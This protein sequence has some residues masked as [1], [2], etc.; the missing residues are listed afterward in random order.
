MANNPSLNKFHWQSYTKGENAEVLIAGAQAYTAQTTYPNFQANAADGEV[1]VF[2]ATTLAVLAANGKLA[3]PAN[4]AVATS[5]T[6]GSITAN[7]YF[8][9]VTAVNSAGQTLASNEVSITTTGAT[10]SNTLTWSPVAGATSYNVWRGTATGAEG[11]FQTT[12]ATNFVDTSAGGGTAGT[13]PT[14]NTATSATAPALVAGQKFFVA[15]RRDNYCKTTTAIQYDANRTRRIPYLAP[16]LQQSTIVIDTSLYTFASG[17][18]IEIALIET[19]TGN[20]PWPTWAYDVVLGTVVGGVAQSSLDIGLQTIVNRINNVNDLVHRDDVL[21]GQTPFNASISNS[22]TVYTIT[23]TAGFFGEN[24]RIA[25]RGPILGLAVTTTTVPF[26]L[27]SGFYAHV[28]QLE[29][30]G[31]VFEGVTTNYPGE[32]VTPADFGYPSSYVV[33][34]LT[35]NIYALDPVRRVMEPNAINERVHYPHLYIICPVPVGANAAARAASS[36]D[37][38]IGTILGFTLAA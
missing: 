37:Y 31:W 14:T 22:G 10:S 16:V 33:N 29:K 8:Y 5:A 9:V 1:G 32:G 20:E 35:Y 26:V 23:I 38:T 11:N 2:D 4:L 13:L 25:T 17:D 7:T 6:G 30:E 12:S 36:P 19:T 21:L 18:D 24:F 34:G 28:L 3:N 27:G 15:Q